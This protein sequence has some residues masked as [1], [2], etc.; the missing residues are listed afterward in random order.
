[1]APGVSAARL[2]ERAALLSV[3][4]SGRP[5]RA[6]A[7]A[8]GELRSQAVQLTGATGGAAPVFSLD[9]EPPRVRDRYGRHR[10]GQAMLLA[11]RLAEAHVPMIA[12]H[13][14]EMTICDGWDTHSKNFEALQTELLPMVDQILSAFLDDLEQRGLL[15]QTV[16][17]VL[18]VFGR[19][20]R[21]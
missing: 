1:L 14:N 12:I 18:G 5:S 9:A 21:I 19:T 17:A 3:L 11:R 4:E 16:V 10:F 8:H 13:F 6:A 7:R 20:P 2:Q 15:G